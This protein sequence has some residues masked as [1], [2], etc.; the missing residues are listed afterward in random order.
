MGKTLKKKIESE[1]IGTHI[2]ILN[3]LENNENNENENEKQ[4]YDQM[5]KQLQKLNT[6][7][8][9]N[10]IVQNCKELF[11][12]STFEIK[13]D[14]NI[15][16]IGFNN[17]VYDLNIGTFRDGHPDDYISL[18]TKLNYIQFN[19]TEDLFA[20]IMFFFEQLFPNQSKSVILLLSSFLEGSNG[21]ESLN[22]WKGNGGRN[23]ISTLLKLI[24]KSFGE[25][26]IC[27]PGQ[28]LKQTIDIVR[29]TDLYIVR[30]KGIRFCIT[31]DYFNDGEQTLAMNIIKSY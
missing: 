19:E 14:S 24:Q 20:E 21:E 11:Y 4:K 18:N 28:W 15:H 8:F 26:F 16:L 12:D 13:L 31:D 10:Q 2:I 25:Y 27:I 3:Y 7:S 9:K 1:I 22:I 23:G 5:I 29:I 17:G 30:L 6:S